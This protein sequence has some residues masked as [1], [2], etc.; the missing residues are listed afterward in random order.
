MIT[1][2]TE[3]IHS[4]SKQVNDRVK[5]Q[6]L[7]LL[8]AVVLLFAAGILSLINDSLGH[9]LLLGTLGLLLVFAVNAVAWALV[10]TFIISRQAAKRPTGRKK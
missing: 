2:M 8:A 3:A 10:F 5:L 7:Y 1:Q 4:W 9:M 6:Q